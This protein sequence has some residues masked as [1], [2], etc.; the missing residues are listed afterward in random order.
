LSD[1]IV[2]RVT[3]AIGPFEKL[4]EKMFQEY[5]DSIVAEYPGA[6]YEKDLFGAVVT[7]PRSSME[8]PEDVQG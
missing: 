4:S 1:M 3:P 6:S 7:M 5:L 8:I 2:F